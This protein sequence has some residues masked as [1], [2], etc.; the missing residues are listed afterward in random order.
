MAQAR[1]P[2]GDEPD[3]EPINRGTPDA[4]AAGT[5]VEDKV[6][7]ECGTD[8][9]TVNLEAHTALHYPDVAHLHDPVYR[10]EHRLGKERRQQL[11]DGGVSRDEFDRAHTVTEE[12]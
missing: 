1:V 2:L 9:S 5:L 7:P 4:V 3:P 11:L 6:C 10:H 8:L 12:D